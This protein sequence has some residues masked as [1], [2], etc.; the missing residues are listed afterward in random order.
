MAAGRR[1][2][3]TWDGPA[4]LSSGNENNN[5]ADG[6]SAVGQVFAD[7]KERMSVNSVADPLTTADF[8]DV[9]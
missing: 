9:S 3:T 8:G 4:L 7:D 1:K 6:R 2:P 5:S